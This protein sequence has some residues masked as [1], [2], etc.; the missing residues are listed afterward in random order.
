MKAQPGT[1][2]FVPQSPMGPPRTVEVSE[3]GN[4]LTDNGVP[5]HYSAEHDRYQQRIPPPPAEPPGEWHFI[6]ISASQ[7]YR[8]YQMMDSGAT[9]P[10]EYGVDV[11]NG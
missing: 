6:I 2:T 3:D 8:T 1:H 7:G 4:T 5:H 11:W 9:L 10:E